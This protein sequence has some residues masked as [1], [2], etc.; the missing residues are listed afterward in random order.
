M[1]TTRAINLNLHDLW[2][3]LRKGDEDA[4]GHFLAILIRQGRDFFLPQIRPTLSK[5]SHMTE[6]VLMNV[7][8][9]ICQKAKHG[10]LKPMATFAQFWNHLKEFVEKTTLEVVRFLRMTP[11]T[12]EPMRQLPAGDV[13]VDPRPAD[14]ER[15][16]LLHSRRDAM[17]A[18][19]ERLQD[20]D[21]QIVRLVLE[22]KKSLEIGGA[23]CMEPAAVRQ[24]IHRI[25]DQLKACLN[26]S[27]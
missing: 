10:T 14:N 23:L 22:G 16:G 15:R 8:A 5:P 18:A 17:L 25:I 6:Q 12:Q 24:R 4:L 7:G 13:L 3:R 1:N 9:K 27:A 20:P 11:R 26:T 21:R 2:E 19:I